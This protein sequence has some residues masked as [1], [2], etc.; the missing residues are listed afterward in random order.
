MEKQFVVLC[1][2]WIKTGGPEALHQLAFHLN[3]TPN[4]SCAIFYYGKRSAAV[5]N[6]YQQLYPVPR[7]SQLDLPGAH[8]VFPESFDPKHVPC[9][10]GGTRWVWWLSANRH[11]PI[12]HYEECGHLFQSEYARVKLH[13]LGV[14]GLMLTDYLRD[15]FASAPDAS[16][17][18]KSWIAYN[19][20]KS[21]LAAMTLARTGK[22]TLVPIKQMTAEQVRKTL[23][24]CKLYIDFGPHPGR[25][26]L[27][28]EAVVNGCMVVTGLE[29]AAGNKIDVPIP[30]GYK[31]SMGQLSQSS[32]FFEE[33]L[34]QYEQRIVEFR[35]YA[36]AVHK[37]K[38]T[39]LKE[40]DA[41][42][43][44]VDTPQFHTRHTFV[45]PDMDSFLLKQEFLMREREFVMLDQASVMLAEKAIQLNL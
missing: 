41:L 39:F 10:K 6:E 7:I 31:L 18:R 29:G 34:S 8:I 2:G 11:Y 14:K 30:S 37:Q 28:R 13:T 22:F 23:S 4:V 27:P 35:H 15:L 19:A 20:A 5:I 9:P 16:A 42:V 1:P 38:A 44:A 32:D 25:D 21:A 24:Q 12:N 33:L 17:E 26:R 43:S 3:E 36:K 40:V 45:E